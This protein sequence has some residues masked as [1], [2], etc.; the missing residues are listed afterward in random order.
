MGAS[1]SRKYMTRP[2]LIR[3]DVGNFL[4][5]SVMVDMILAELS[6]TGNSTTMQQLLGAGTDFFDLD[7]QLKSYPAFDHDW[8]PVFRNHYELAMSLRCERGELDV[9]A[10]MAPL[11]RRCSCEQSDDACQ[12]CRALDDWCRRR[13]GHRQ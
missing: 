7:G 1:I 8:T 13:E 4:M 12:F 3:M 5:Y 9:S 2:R 6:D 11:A 10:T